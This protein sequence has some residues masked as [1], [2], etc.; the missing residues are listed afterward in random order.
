MVVLVVVLVEV[1]VDG[2]CLKTVLRAVAAVTFGFAVVLVVDD[3][4]FFVQITLRA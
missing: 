2:A 4:D 3:P 1:V